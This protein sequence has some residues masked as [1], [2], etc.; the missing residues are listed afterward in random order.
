MFARNRSKERNSTPKVT[1]PSPS[2]MTNER[3][4]TPSFTRHWTIQFIAQLFAD[5]SRSGLP[6][7]P[8]QQP[9][10][11]ACRRPSSADLKTRCTWLVQQQPALC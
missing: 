6:C 3:F 2:Y 8:A 11:Q 4:G 5:V 7:R 10:Q 1:P 9:R